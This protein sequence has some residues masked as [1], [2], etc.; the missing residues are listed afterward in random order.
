MKFLKLG[1][2]YGGPQRQYTNI[3]CIPAF[4]AS[5]FASTIKYTLVQQYLSQ[6]RNVNFSTTI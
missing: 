5:I 1:E 6:H 4:C 2:Y 3:Y